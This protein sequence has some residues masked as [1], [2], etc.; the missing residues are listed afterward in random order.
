MAA[1][2]PT[3][4]PRGHWPWYALI[5]LALAGLVVYALRDGTR[6]DDSKVT[7]P[8]DP[9][10]AGPAKPATIQETP[11]TTVAAP[12]GSIEAPAT[13]AAPPSDAIVTASGLAS[14]V[15]V[16]GTGTEHPTTEARVEVHYTGWTTDG[17]MFDSSIVRGKTATFPLAGVIK[18]WTEGV[19]L[20]VVG[21]R[22]RFWIPAALA[23]GNKPGARWACWCSTS[24]SAP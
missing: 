22:R 16:A 12:S 1:P 18:G 9:Q 17:K 11:M 8:N 4:T 15:L 23:Y 5:S 7:A 19:Q 6:V 20:M 10:K 13:V 3:V 14:K 24:S 21:E 2:T